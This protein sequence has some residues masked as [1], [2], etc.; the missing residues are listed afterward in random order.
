MEIKGIELLPKPVSTGRTAA[1]SFWARAVGIPLIIILQLLFLSVLAFRI[2]LE[3]DLSVLAESVAQKERIL[4]QSAEFARAF[5]ETQ[6]RLALL[7]QVSH[8]ICSA[9]A[10]QT[11]EGLAPA[12]V[13]ITSLILREEQAEVSARAA[14]GAPFAAFVANILE[15]EAVRRAAIVSGGLDQSGNFVFAIELTLDREEVGTR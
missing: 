1:I 12:G 8:E 7:R 6:D 11:V 2:K 13:E 15:E 14:Q 4:E 9:C 10:F 3:V 5:L